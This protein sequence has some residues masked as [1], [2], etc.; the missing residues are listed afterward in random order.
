MKKILTSI[1]IFLIMFNFIF[2]YTSVATED[3]TYG[4]SEEEFD[5]SNNEGTT[6]NPGGGTSNVNYGATTSTS[7]AIVGILAA[8]FDA[9]PML[10]NELMNY[11]CN[12]GGYIDFNITMDNVEE[13]EFKLI[14]IEK[15]VFGNYYLFNYNILKNSE[16]LKV[17]NKDGVEYTS[18]NATPL[19]KTL[20]ELRKEVAKWYYIMRLIS[21]VLGLLTLIYVGIR[22]AISTV[23]EEQAKYKKMLIAWVQSI[24]IIV[25]LP[26][27][28][29][30]INYIAD[31][32]MSLITSFKTSLEASGQSGFEIEIIKSIYGELGTK[33]RNDVSSVFYSILYTNFC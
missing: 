5:K 28:M 33:R 18:A 6:S 31:V 16:E 3:I 11:L 14:T 9:L 13:D 12:E 24:I 27:L 2:G 20:D 7:G 4:L 25:I 10:A 8:V 32:L 21:L 29:V 19:I 26:Y 22:M 17:T 30:I 1:L 23:A 15:I